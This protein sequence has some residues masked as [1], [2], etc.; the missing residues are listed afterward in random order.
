MIF[1]KSPKR[2]PIVMDPM[3]K[4]MGGDVNYGASTQ[5]GSNT[6]Q[7]VFSDNNRG[8]AGYINANRG[9]YAFLRSN[10][11]HESLAGGHTVDKKITAPYFRSS[12]KSLWESIL[13]VRER[14]DMN[15]RQIR[16]NE[17]SNTGT[18][19]PKKHTYEYKTDYHRLIKPVVSKKWI[20]YLGAGLLVYFVLR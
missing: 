17:F 2:G 6:I 13:G 20:V 3:S 14:T 10:P 8:P 18:S 7:N 1:N 15:R 16:Y 5:V 12:V 4:F 11:Y 19:V 9:D